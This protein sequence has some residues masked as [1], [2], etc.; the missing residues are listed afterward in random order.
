MY[1]VVHVKL[2]LVSRQE[3]MDEHSEDD[4]DE[5]EDVS[6]NSS[7]TMPGLM[8]RSFLQ[9]VEDEEEDED[10][11]MAELRQQQKLYDQEVRDLQQIVDRK[12]AEIQSISSVILK[13]WGTISVK[14]L[15]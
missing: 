6:I 9:D 5:E 10:E 15:Y 3:E 8:L 11:E 12:Q 1:A 13:V 4:E 7:G 2:I 14:R